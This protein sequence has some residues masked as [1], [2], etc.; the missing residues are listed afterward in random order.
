MSR[1][2]KKNPIRKDTSGSSYRSYAK[3]QANRK[4]RRT[5]DV[6][7][8]KVYRKF[9]ETWNINDWVFRWDPKPYYVHD[10]NG[11][12]KRIDPDPEW[13]AWMK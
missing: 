9:F 4:I 3:N 12:L 10:I 8:G 5:S 1:S 2:R 7:D 11:N 13:K 6:P